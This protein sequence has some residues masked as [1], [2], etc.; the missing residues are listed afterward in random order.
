[1]L[2]PLESVARRVPTA[3]A[4]LRTRMAIW[5]A[6]GAGLAL[7]MALLLRVGIPEVL[8]IVSTAGWRLLW[9][10]PV[11]IAPLA[12]SAIGWRRVIPAADAP[13]RVYLTWAAAVREAIG[14]LLPTGP[15]GGDVA[16]VWLLVRRVV[17]VP[18]AGASV[19][20]ETT[21]WMIAQL[22]FA[23]VG[24][25]LLL[26]SSTSGPMPRWVALG[27]L[28]GAVAIAAFILAQHRWDLFRQLQRVLGAIAGKEVFRAFGDAA[29]LDRA[30]RVLYRD[31]RSVTVCLVWQLASLCAGALELWIALHL[32]GQPSSMRAALVI[33]SVTEAVRS[34][35]F[36]VPAGLG[37]QEGS[38]LL[39]GAAVGLSPGASL[40][41]SLACRARQLLLG[42]PAI[43][44][45][46]WSERSALARWA[47][48]NLT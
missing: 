10:V 41:L 6:G 8:R 44:S 16:G 29:R 37:T 30:I 17:D 26:T 7:A 19:V 21:I 42:I 5:A 32:L 23:G 22:I 31:R 13:G 34:A 18:T 25:M 1:M 3:R 47:G 28:V 27:L 36:F 43:G 40:A 35:T 2:L 14:G 48:R 24:L 11:H 20:V 33:A 4:P 45:M 39:I 15:V 12:L 9:L 46:L 38:F